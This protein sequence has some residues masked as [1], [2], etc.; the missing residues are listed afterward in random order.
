MFCAGGE[1]VIGAVDISTDVYKLHW[2]EYDNRAKY[3]V[4]LM[5]ARTQ[6]PYQFADYKTLNCCLATFVNVKR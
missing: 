3:I 5:I 1:M 4:R 2:Y 6:K